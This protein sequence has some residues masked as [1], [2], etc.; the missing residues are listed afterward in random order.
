MRA[1]MTRE[2]VEAEI[3][4]VIIS[5]PGPHTPEHE[6][7]LV[8]VKYVEGLCFY[9]CCVCRVA[10]GCICRVAGFSACNVHPPIQ[11]HPFTTPQ[12]W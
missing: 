9:A 5:Q 6:V 12:G 3:T 10:G 8:D 1:K 11:N 2:S 7:Q 4:E